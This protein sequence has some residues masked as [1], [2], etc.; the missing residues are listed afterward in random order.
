MSRLLNGDISYD[1]LDRC[2]P[3]LA[4]KGGK[5]VSYD[6]VLVGEARATSNFGGG[7]LFGFFLIH[8]VAESKV[9][10]TAQG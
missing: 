2:S 8:S 1:S 9:A 10:R 7:P 6:G 3:I 4:Q 5:I